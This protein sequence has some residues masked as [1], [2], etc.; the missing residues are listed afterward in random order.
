MGAKRKKKPKGKDPY[1]ALKRKA[2]PLGRNFADRIVVDPPGVPKMSGVLMEFIEPYRE[3]PE[4]EEKLKFILM[5]GIL[6][7]NLAFLD[8]D[9][10]RDTINGYL[11]DV[12]PAERALV[13]M[14][15][16]EMVDRKLLFYSHDQRWILNF[17]FT[18]TPNGPYLQV[19]SSSKP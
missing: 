8:E 6:A 1:A 5:F 11:K 10:R 12:P 4:D 13:R 2:A 18:M 19:L 16:D 7:W 15:F 9:E 3:E 17:E 14:T